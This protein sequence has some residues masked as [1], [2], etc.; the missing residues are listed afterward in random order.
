MNEK[1]KFEVIAVYHATK[2][3]GCVEAETSEEAIEIV[4]S[5]EFETYVSLCHECASELELVDGEPYRFDAWEAE[6][7]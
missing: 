4:E 1:K 6:N 3:I 5:G 2:Y 7:D